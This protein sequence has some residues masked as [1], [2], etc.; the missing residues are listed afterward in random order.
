MTFIRILSLI[1]LFTCLS[2]PGQ[3]EDR[4]QTLSFADALFNEGDHYR[5]ITEYKRFLHF[6][7][8]DGEAP[9]AALRIAESYL[10]GRRWAEAEK[11][12][13]RLRH[14]YPETDEAARAALL[15]AE[16]PYRQGDFPA[17]GRRFLQIVEQPPDPATGAAA[18]Y[19]LAWSLIEEDRFAAAGQQLTQLTD[20]RAA[21][22]AAEMPHLERLPQKSPRLAGGLSAI[23]PG[24]GQLYAGRPHDAALAFLLNAAFIAGA[25]ESF[26]SGN[27]VVGGILLF[28]E[29]GWYTGNIYNAANST[30]KFNRDLRE[31]QKR[32]L[33]ERF[34]VTLGLL[35]GAPVVGMNL[36]F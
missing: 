27:E 33:R 1:V 4:Q 5:A 6:F 24:A 17:A 19:R 20:A 34:G 9:R 16:V 36:R 14:D 13:A 26:D 31:E 8:A 32:R 11:A 29:A 7:P 23:L 12:L 22:L 30:H 15:W 35:E 3:A 10:A 25:W 21:D 28:F 18:R 2:Q